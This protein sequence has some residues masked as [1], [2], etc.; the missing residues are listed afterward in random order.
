MT[1][2]EK[3]SE[4]VQKCLDDWSYAAVRVWEIMSRLKKV[5]ELLKEQEA[6]K[7]CCKDCEYYGNCHS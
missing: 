2:I 1:N 7:T 6:E 5:K 3:A 4:L